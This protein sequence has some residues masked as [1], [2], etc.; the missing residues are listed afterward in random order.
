[1]KTQEGKAEVRQLGLQIAAKILDGVL[2]EIEKAMQLS[3][4]DSPAL[5]GI[6]KAHRRRNRRH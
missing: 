5:R 4:E 1:M 2:A 3:G 6:L